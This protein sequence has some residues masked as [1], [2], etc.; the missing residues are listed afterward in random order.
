MTVSSPGPTA[1][2]QPF[3]RRRTVAVG[4]RAVVSGGVE[5][6]AAQRAGGPARFD[7]PGGL[8]GEGGGLLAGDGQPGD[9]PGLVFG[10]Q[11]LDDQ[12]D[13]VVAL[14]VGDADGPHHPGRFGRLLQLELL[15]QVAGPGWS[16]TMRP[17]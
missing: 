6:R 12:D 4:P 15:G 13:P 7:Q 1:G 11:L 14:V 8:D 9:G 10:D 17:R 2:L 3:T 5:G 16:R